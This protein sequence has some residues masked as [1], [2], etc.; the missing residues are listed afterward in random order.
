MYLVGS[1]TTGPLLHP[2]RERRKLSISN[3][4]TLVTSVTESNQRKYHNLLAVQRL[5]AFGTIC[6][7]A[8]E[9]RDAIAMVKQENSA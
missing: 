9:L 4:T 6:N 8:L 7:G 3:G 5:G 1:L 2:A